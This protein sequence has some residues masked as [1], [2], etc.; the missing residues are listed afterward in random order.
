MVFAIF[1]FFVVLVFNCQFPIFISCIHTNNMKEL[2]ILICTLTFAHCA[3]ATGQSG[4]IIYINGE[5]W[6]LLGKPID[7][8]EKLSKNL[9]EALP[10]N[11]LVITSNW[12]RYTA[13]WS[14]ANERLQL[15]SIICQL[16][17][18]EAREAYTH[19]I[20]I[21]DM[22]RIF[23][24]YYEGSTIVA[25]WLSGNI[26]AA[27]GDVLLY[28]HMGFR[29]NHEYEQI[30]TIKNGRLTKQQSFRNHI[31]SK[32]FIPDSLPDPKKIFKLD[33]ESDPDFAELDKVFFHVDHV[34]LDSL[35]NMLDCNVK[36]EMWNDRYKLIIKKYCEKVKT[37]L[38]KM[39]PWQT[40]F[41][42][43][44]YVLKYKHGFGFMYRLRDKKK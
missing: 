42:N 34:R 27:K 16:Y 11:V 24:K 41:I 18:E 39:H 29:R 37:I 26:R 13:Y 38:L 17:N 32:G 33:I 7:D 31:V 20:P 21:N 2:I 3:F 4:D 15:D 1:V 35:G 9:A 22:Q 6:H 44:E 14:V 19:R 36:A 43:G 8:K 30:L 28:E 23:K 5:E 12:S 25:S 40:Y 10:K